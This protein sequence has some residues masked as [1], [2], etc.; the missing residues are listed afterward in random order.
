M[1][2]Q[3]AQV[4]IAPIPG[5]VTTLAGGAMFGFG[6]ALAYS[7]IAILIGALIAF[8]I[9]RVCGRPLV[10]KLAPADVV[11][12]YLNVLAGKQR[13]TL[14]LMFLFPFFPDDVLCILACHTQLPFRRFALI[15]LCARPWGLLFASALGGASLSI[16]LWAMVLIGL[17]GVMI[18]VLG[19][20]Y[21]DRL[22]RAILKRLGKE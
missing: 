5:N 2:L 1:L 8:G 19:M 15:A 18:F 9:G 21:G 22:E 14:A 7:T 12:K 4:I 20:L 11:D 13:M 6:P 17:A 16:P 10:N 3:I